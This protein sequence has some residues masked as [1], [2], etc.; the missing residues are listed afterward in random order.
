MSLPVIRIFYPADPV[1]LIPG[2]IDTFIRGILNWAPDDLVFELVGVTTSPQV[3]PV[4]Q[5]T[6]CTLARRTFRFF[7]VLVLD[8]AGKRSHIPLSLRYTT[9]TLKH[10]SVLQKDCDAMDFHRLEPAM[11]WFFD[12]RPKSLYQHQNMAILR[13]NKADVLWKHAPGLFLWLEKILLPRFSRVWCVREDAV[14]DYRKRFPL[15]AKNVN[16]CPTWMDP[17]VFFPVTNTAREILRQEMALKYGLRL[18]RRWL[19]FVGRIDSQKNPLLLIDSFARL[20][21]DEQ[22]TELLMIGDGVLAEEARQCASSQGVADRVHFLGL[23]SPHVIADLLRSADLFVLSSAYEGM[24][25]CVLEALGCG[26]PCVATDVGEVRRVV[27]SG[28]NGE[29]SESHEVGAFTESISRAL[30]AG[31]VYRGDPCTKAVFDYTPSRVLD[32][33]FAAYRQILSESVQSI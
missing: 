26:L 27:M 1:G 31:K 2:G 16:F 9:A 21:E 32:S 22:N 33:V 13:N 3:R 12:R 11:V 20:K 18:D 10:M 25:M 28:I 8:D 14:A 7:P 23:Q 19:V 4:G 29:I 6:T 17:D 24:P 5:W 15:L 30:S